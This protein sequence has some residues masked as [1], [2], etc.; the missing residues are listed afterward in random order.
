MKLHDLRQFSKM[1]RLPYYNDSKNWPRKKMKS[2]LSEENWRLE[3]L[4]LLP[5]FSCGASPPPASAS[6][7]LFFS[8]PPSSSP[9]PFFSS[10]QAVLLALKMSLPWLKK[11]STPFL[12]H[13]FFYLKLADTIARYKNRNLNQKTGSDDSSLGRYVFGSEISYNKPPPRLP[14]LGC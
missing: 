13:L 12:K 2:W 9:P 4:H 8:C 11:R 6:P 5:S 10:L 1:Y 3:W 7:P 14:G